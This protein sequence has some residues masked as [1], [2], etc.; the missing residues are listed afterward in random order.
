MRIIHS[1]V[2]FADF[3]SEVVLLGHALVV[4]CSVKLN[5]LE[6]VAPKWY[7]GKYG[8][9]ADFGLQVLVIRCAGLC[10]VGL[11]YFDNKLLEAIILGHKGNNKA[12]H[13]K[14]LYCSVKLMTC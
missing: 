7:Q 4:T 6:S 9:M 13:P 12:K 10:A 8:W 5:S 3:D 2:N 1:P 14:C 11:V